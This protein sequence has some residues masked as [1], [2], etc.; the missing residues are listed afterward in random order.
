MAAPEHRARCGLYHAA[1]VVR[2]DGGR[3]TIEIAPS[4]TPTMGSRGVVATGAVGT[5]WIGWM[6]LFRYE[7]R[8]WRG[9]TIPDLVPGVSPARASLRA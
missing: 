5:R 4:P 3:H 6:R 1:L 9:G 2:L 7:V 8:C